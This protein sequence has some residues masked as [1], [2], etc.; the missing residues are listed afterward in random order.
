[1]TVSSGASFFQLILDL[2]VFV[3]SRLVPS[4]LV[5]SCHVL[6]CLVL[7]CHVLSCPASATFIRH[8]YVGVC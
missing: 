3:P 4:C 5:F 1:M 7:S 6:S 8:T 2:A